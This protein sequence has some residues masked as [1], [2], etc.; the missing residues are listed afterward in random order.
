MTARCSLDELKQHAISRG[1]ICCS[2]EYI[3]NRLPIEWKCSEGHNWKA[4][5]DGI[6]NQSQWCPHCAGVARTSLDI[7]H[8][9][10]LYRDGK[11]LSL[12][13]CNAHDKLDWECSEGHN[14][15]AAWHDILSHGSW[16][17][18]CAGL[19]KP[20]ISE[21]QQYAIFKNGLLLSQIYAG[22]KSALLWQCSK[23]H[24]WKAKWS[25]IKNKNSWCPHCKQ[26]KTEYKCKEL[27]E[28]K[29]GFEFKK[30][31]FNY[32][33]SRYEFDGYNEENKIAFEY[34][35]IQHYIFTNHWHKTKEIFLA[36]Q[37]RDR[38]KEQYCIENN[39]QLL[40]IPYTEEKK[41]DSYITSLVE[42]IKL[43]VNTNL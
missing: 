17:P 11:C 39:I 27:L 7:L 32:N 21:L 30:T 16:C 24:T 5:W 14:W 4:T 6:K 28:S 9:H 37:E 2:S 12:V 34:H 8:Q 15:K 35:G 10:A 20:D 26:F 23:G 42:N 31:R 29:F 33:E 18:Y 25:D 38:K 41:L 19:A 13:Y 40:L 1:G 36:A 22:S 3:N 43:K